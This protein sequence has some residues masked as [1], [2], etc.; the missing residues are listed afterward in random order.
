MTL[1][2]KR[3]TA[4]KA[5]AAALCTA[6][7]AALAPLLINY[8][9]FPAF[10][11]API[12][13]AWVFLAWKTLAVRDRRILIPGAVLAFF[14][15]LS[16]VAGGKFRMA[17]RS[18]VPF[19]HRSD[20]LY[21]AVLSA[22]FFSVLVPAAAAL[23]RCWFRVAADARPPRSPAVWALGSVFLF[24]CWAP[25]LA[26]YYPGCI[27]PDSLACI[28]RAVGIAGLSNQQPVLYIL[29]MRPFLLLSQSAGRSLNFGCVLFLLTQAAA[30]AAMLGYVPAWILKKGGPRW[31]AALGLVFFAVVPVFPMY[32]VTMWK[33]VP[34][35]GL[36]TLYAL[37][38]YDI[39]QS[40][41]EWLRGRNLAWFL[42]LNLLIAFLR[43]N[44]YCV[45][46]VTLVLLAFV[47]RKKWKRLV[48]AFLAVLILV[49][50]VQGPAYRHLSI[51]PTPFAE[52]L[53]IPLQQ[54]GYTVAHDGKVTA[55]QRDFLNRLLPYEEIKTAYNPITANG[56]K[57]H[58]DFSDA[59]LE[60]NKAGFLRVWAGMLAPNFGSYVKAYILE[61]VGYWHVGT[62]GWIL[63]YGTGEGY[64]AEEKGL[65]LSASVGG[66]AAQ[67]M[68]DNVRSSFET[69]QY[70][71][72]PLSFLVNIGFLFWTTVFAAFILVLKK[73]RRYF[74]AFL[75]LLLIWATLM[76]AS[77]SY[78]EFR[79]M[80]SF[81]TALPAFLA[82]PFLPGGVSPPPSRAVEAK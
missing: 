27:S 37:D 64:G 9:K 79:Y 54:I 31:A 30:M 35:A 21:L 40:R 73:G 36:V 32:A 20:L 3:P 53:A 60:N 51:D 28:V 77:P 34:F 11:F 50:A 57:F 16:F 24:L 80:F 18:L 19:Y 2:N 66:S 39:V 69:F 67:S 75:P 49:P 59:F 74:L 43:N 81:A 62:T 52:S 56:I 8:F 70:Q 76:A 1:K 22:A 47:Y 55:Q 78:C 58:P 12:V 42:A 61:T 17:D 26:V 68:R 38:L 46:G 41:G 5:I 44:G 71:M 63:Y 6:V 65:R 10:W 72:K 7:C 45:I 33:D 4:R 13:A 15:A 25:S 14:F 48:P 23:K 82:M 29:L